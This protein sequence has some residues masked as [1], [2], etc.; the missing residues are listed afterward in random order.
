MLNVDEPWMQGGH[1]DNEDLF[2]VRHV[3]KPWKFDT[4]CHKKTWWISQ[5]FVTQL[6]VEFVMN[7]LFVRFYDL[8]GFVCC[9]GFSIMCKRFIVFVYDVGV[10]R[11][12]NGMVA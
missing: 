3:D 6:N 1:V 9:C 5:R 4:I 8:H 12:Q 11:F 7:M 2:H 10:H